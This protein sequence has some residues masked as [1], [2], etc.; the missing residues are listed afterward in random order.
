MGTSLDKLRSFL[1]DVGD[2]R[3]AAFVM[4][5]SL[6]FS[7]CSREL[8]GPE[9]EQEQLEDSFIAIEENKNNR[10]DING[11]H[12]TENQRRRRIGDRHCTHTD[13]KWRKFR[14]ASSHSS[15]VQVNT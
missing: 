5:V 3:R 14:R 10:I 13:T 7:S 8:V 11:L 1:S 4:Y 9:G 12:A 6:F 2:I 15:W